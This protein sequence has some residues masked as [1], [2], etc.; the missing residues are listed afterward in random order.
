M[1]NTLPNQ[2]VTLSEIPGTVADVATGNIT[3]SAGYVSQNRQDGRIGVQVAYATVGGAKSH[4]LVTSAGRHVTVKTVSD[5]NRLVSGLMEKGVPAVLG[6]VAVLG[7]VKPKIIDTAEE[8]AAVVASIDK[9]RVSIAS[10]RTALVTRGQAIIADAAPN[11]ADPGAIDANGYTFASRA[12][13]AGDLKSMAKLEAIELDLE[14]SK[15]LDAF[16]AAK[17]A[18]VVANTWSF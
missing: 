4:A 13:V 1:A 9:Q 17:R 10:G 11:V 7:V 8:R 12:E 2:A 6:N 15:D 16:L 3:L 18:Q 5:V 14:S